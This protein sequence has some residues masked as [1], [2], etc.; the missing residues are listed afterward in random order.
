MQ[1]ATKENDGISGLVPVPK[2]GDQESF[3]RGDGTWAPIPSSSLSIDTNIFT[4]TSSNVLT[5]KGLET[6]EPGSLLALD[7][8]NQL[9]YVSKNNF[10][11]KD[12]VNSLLT[13]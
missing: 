13:G 8:N 10:Y 11:T 4:K 12:E 3:L 6:A 5:L 9:T 7:D 1:G 2:A